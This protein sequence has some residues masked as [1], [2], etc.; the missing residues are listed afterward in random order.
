MVRNKSNYSSHC[1][2]LLFSTKAYALA[3]VVP[4]ENGVR[5]IASNQGMEETDF[6]LLCKK[7]SI[8][9]E[10]EKAIADTAKISKCL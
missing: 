2:Y 7:E 3:F 1:K 9:K 6:A 10:I 8:V 5:S 4:N